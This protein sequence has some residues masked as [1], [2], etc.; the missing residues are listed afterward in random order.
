MTSWNDLGDYYALLL[1][2]AQL[3]NPTACLHTGIPILFEENHNPW[4][5]LDDLVHAADGRHNLAAYLVAIFLYR[6]NGDAGDNDTVRQYMRRVEGEE[7]SWAAMA[8]GNGGPMSRWL[9][10]K[11]CVLCRRPAAKGSTK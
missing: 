11:G 5:C 2:L 1:I 3:G 10:N 9:W 8:G 7:E 6:H 4:P